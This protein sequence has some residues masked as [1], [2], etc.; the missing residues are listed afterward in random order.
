MKGE[1]RKIKSVKRMNEK[2]EWKV[3]RERDSWRTLS[4]L[5]RIEIT[6]TGREGD[7]ERVRGI[8]RNKDGHRE[9]G[10]LW[11]RQAVTE[12]AGERERERKRRIFVHVKTVAYLS[13]MVVLS[14]IDLSPA[15]GATWKD[16][17][18]HILHESA[19]KFTTKARA[20]FQ[21]ANHTRKVKL[22][23]VTDS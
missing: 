13:K 10:R 12:I 3:D 11:G 18:N 9:T 16:Q 7:E 20:V 19:L 2:N 22:E 14:K 8:H 6:K 4:Y 1:E 21:A 15:L 23:A 5:E 17:I